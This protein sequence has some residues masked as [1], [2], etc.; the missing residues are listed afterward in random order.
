MKTKVLIVTR[1]FMHKHLGHIVT[2]V[3]SAFIVLALALGFTQFASAQTFAPITAQAGPGSSGVHVSNIQRFLAS[4]PSFYPQG[5]VTGYFGALTQ[6]AVQRFQA[7][8]GIVSSGSPS[9]TGYGRVGPTT[10]AKMNSL[11]LGGPTTFD[12]AAPYISGVTVSTGSNSA[13][14]SWATNELATGRLYYSTVPI[15]FNE[16]NENS[17]GFAVTSGQSASYDAVTRVSHGATL[18]GLSANTTYYYL[19][20]ATDPSGN[21]SISLPGATFRTGF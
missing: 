19:I 7:F 18:T 6:A 15:S 17:V 1:G 9:S 12:S 3:S 14:V 20:V 4:T 13:T 8:Y 16:G 21:V 11:I 2:F 5:L 10:L